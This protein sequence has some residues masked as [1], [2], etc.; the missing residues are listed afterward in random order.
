MAIHSPIAQKLS[1]F[2][3]ITH[4][5]PTEGKAQSLH[6]IST[7]EALI[8]VLQYQSALTLAAGSPEDPVSKE[9]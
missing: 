6:V 3:L 5:Y 2:S 9:D 8:V 1:Y 7:S 4:T